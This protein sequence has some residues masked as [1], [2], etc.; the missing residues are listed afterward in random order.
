MKPLD[1]D[2]VFPAADRRGPSATPEQVSAAERDLGVR[3]PDD[4]RT[5]LAEVGSFNGDLVGRAADP[6]YARFFGLEE[7]VEGSRSQEEE[8]WPFALVGDSGAC[9]KYVWRTTPA[10]GGE[11]ILYDF[12]A[13]DVLET[14]GRSFA[15]LLE[16]L[17]AEQ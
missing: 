16:R 1:F 14:Y 2:R 3:F 7:V 17:S 12:G 13:G 5:F 9:W 8:P 10:G 11:F 15:A 4:Y 6:S